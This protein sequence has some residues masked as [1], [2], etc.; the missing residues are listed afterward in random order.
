[1][2]AINGVHDPAQF[3]VGEEHLSLFNTLDEKELHEVLFCPIC[4]GESLL[5]DTVKTINSHSDITVQLR[6]CVDCGHWWIDPMP[7]QKYLSEL[8]AKGSE[9]VVPVGY[10]GTCKCTEDLESAV[11]RYT[12]SCSKRDFNY[13]DVGSSAGGIIEAFKK[14]ARICYGVEPGYW[15]KGNP[16][17]V[18]DIS[19]IPNDVKFDIISIQ[20]V[21][22]HVEDPVGM[23]RTARE[24]ANP[25]CIVHCGFPNK[26][27]LKARICKGKW[28]MILPFEHLHYFSYPSVVKMFEKAGW[29]LIELRSCRS[30]QVS[31]WGSIKVALHKESA[32]YWLMR[33]PLPIL[34]GKD[35]W[36][37]KGK[38]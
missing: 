12:K 21:L 30:G 5:V 9:F 3:V 36:Y 6:E 34:L 24:L 31:T 25:D 20:D 33:S 17:I 27:A 28:G 37:A 2:K 19:D 15:G 14:K 32:L 7:K 4:K 38:A 26:D 29:G 23:L 22:E 1:M 13:L 11:A 16:N 10:T 35:Q 8:Y 18:S